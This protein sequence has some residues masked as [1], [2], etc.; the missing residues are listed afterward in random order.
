LVNSHMLAAQAQEINLDQ[1]IKLSRGEAKDANSKAR[2]FILADAFE[3][4]IG[5]MYLDQGMSAPKKF[6]TEQ[7]L[8]K[9][10][11]ILK[12]ELYIDAKSKF[13]EIAQAKVGITPSYHV[14]EES[15][16]DHDKTFKIGVYLNHELVATGAGSSKQEAQMQAAQ[17]GLDI[18][19]WNN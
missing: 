5:A 2:L 6:I 13:Q 11:D 8:V 9:L 18:K 19:N 3:A 1:H 10:E 16:P 17:N 4:L 15:G 14:L 7:L 12:N